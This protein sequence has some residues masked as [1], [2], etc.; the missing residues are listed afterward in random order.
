MSGKLK[1]AR[2]ALAEGTAS[3][4]LREL[5]IDTL[6]VD[7]KAIATAKGI[8]VQGKPNFTGGV[9]GTLVK[10]GDEFGIMYATNIPSIGFQKFS[11]AHEIGHYCIEGH[12]DALLSSGAH[13]SHAGFVSA[14]PY[15]QEADYFAAGLLMPETPFCKEMN[16]HDPGLACVDAL[17]KACE[18]SLT[19]TA[20]R[21]ATLTR[22]GAA[23]IISR[24]QEID[25]CFMSEGIKHAKGLSWIKKGTPVPS[26]TVTSAF[27]ARPDNIR[28]GAKDSGD[29]RLNDWMGGERVYRVKEEV[30]GLGQY[31]RT[32]TVLNCRTLSTDPG[33]DDEE[34]DEEALIERWTPQFR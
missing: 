12:C 3:L 34:D 32:L 16:L 33:G 24:G 29:G 5:K 17:A 19:A 1:L 11:I 20:I 25:Y 28:L 4:V 27:N 14:D 13:Y 31:G 7:P 9:S 26:G 10:A 2:K 21:Y 18:T 22:D 15:E 8:T 23:I 6:R 30:V